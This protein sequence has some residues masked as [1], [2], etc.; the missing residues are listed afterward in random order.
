MR[1]TITISLLF[2]LINFSYAQ[3]DSIKLSRFSVDAFSDT[4][5]G[6]MFLTM[7]IFNTITQATE[8]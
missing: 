3:C 7:A 4:V 6:L 5:L 2:F 8:Q 1:N